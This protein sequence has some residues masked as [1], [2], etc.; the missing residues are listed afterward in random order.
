MQAL[1]NFERSYLVRCCQGS[2]VLGQARGLVV[3]VS[4][5]AKHFP[6]LVVHVHMSV[7]TESLHAH[8]QCSVISTCTRHT[9][10]RARAFKHSCLLT[11]IHAQAHIY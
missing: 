7:S 3:T 1:G 8:Y 5:E 2:C 6:A 11:H 4:V 10:S 9:T